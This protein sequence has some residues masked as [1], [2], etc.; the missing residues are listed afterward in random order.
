LDPSERF[1]AAKVRGYP[2]TYYPVFVNLVDNALFW[3]QD[4]KDPAIY[5]DFN[6]EHFLVQDNGPGLH[7]DILE[8]V[9][10]P[11]FTL[12]PGG[13]GLGLAVGRRAMKQIGGDLRVTNESN[14]A[15]FWVIPPLEA[16]KGGE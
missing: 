12:K 14:G 5:L 16:I 8:L 4:R 10:E 2:S 11:S 1:L 13:R 3:L 6:G 15:K 9:F 7:P